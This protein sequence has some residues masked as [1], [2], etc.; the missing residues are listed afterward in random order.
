MKLLEGEEFDPTLNFKAI[1][2]AKGLPE[3]LQNILYYAILLVDGDPKELTLGDALGKI[4]KYSSSLGVYKEGSALLYPMY[5]SGDVSQGFCRVSAVYEGTYVITEELKVLGMLKEED[6]I[7]GII[8]SIGEFH[9]TRILVN[10]TFAS[11]DERLQ[12]IP[13]IAITRGVM[14]CRGIYHVNDGPVLFTLPPGTFDNEF[15][16]YIVQLSSN[17]ST[18]PE[19]YSLLH[20]YTR[21]TSYDANLNSFQMFI[22]QLPLELIFYVTYMHQITV[23]SGELDHIPSPGLGFEITEHFEMAKKIFRDIRGNNEPF[24][25]CRPNPNGE[26]EEF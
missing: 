1:L 20:L 14:L 16:I 18:V 25:P 3:N 23:N 21:T 12:S 17:S 26:E 5:G 2:E 22:A 15:P 13:Q 4:Q 11:I 6:Q 9:G 10:P 7:K 8:T 19:E 24:L